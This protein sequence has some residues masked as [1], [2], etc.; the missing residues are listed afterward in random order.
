MF[1]EFLGDCAFSLRRSPG[2]LPFP[3][4]F[5]QFRV[6]RVESVEFEHSLLVPAARENTNV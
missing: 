1:E 4:S 3:L 5:F 2:Y 6:E